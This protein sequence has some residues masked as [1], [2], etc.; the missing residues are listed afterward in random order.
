MDER[1]GSDSKLPVKVSVTLN[2][3][4]CGTIIDQS[5]PAGMLKDHRMGK[6][7]KREAGNRVTGNQISRR[8]MSE[9]AL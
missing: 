6:V 8:V 4:S 1:T 2:S 9:G 5:G 3:L 7:E